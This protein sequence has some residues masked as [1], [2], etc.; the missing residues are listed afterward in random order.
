MKRV[1][2]IDGGKYYLTRE[3][4]NFGIYQRHSG[5]CRVRGDYVFTNDKI[6]ILSKSFN[7]NKYE[8]GYFLIHP[9]FAEVPL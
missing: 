6:T 8:N 4:R 7:N 1:L 3:Y 5:G 2:N 9:G